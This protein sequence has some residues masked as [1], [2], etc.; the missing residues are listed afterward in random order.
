[1]SGNHDITKGWYPDINL[2]GTHSLETVSNKIRILS[3]SLT[4]IVCRYVGNWRWNVL[5]KDHTFI[6]VDRICFLFP[7]IILLVL[8][9][10]QVRVNRNK[11]R[12]VL[13]VDSRYS[14]QMTSPKRVKHLFFCHTLIF[15]GKF[16][17][18]VEK[19]REN[20]FTLPRQTFIMSPC[21]KEK[22]FFFFHWLFFLS[23]SP[24]WLVGRG[25]SDVRRGAPEELHH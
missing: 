20:V 22:M 23:F 9:C 24:G 2:I 12:G 6:Q 21:N 5:I 13:S 16:S 18:I 4:D 7:M 8:S 10:F 15:L 25:G 14:K 19:H 1:M 17:Q 11:Q 3:L